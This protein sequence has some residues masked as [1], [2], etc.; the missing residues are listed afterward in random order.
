[1]KKNS[2]CLAIAIWLLFAMGSYAEVTLAGDGSPGSPYLISSADDLDAIRNYLHETDAYFKQTGP[3]DLKDWLIENKPDKGWIPIGGEYMKPFKG[4]FDGGGHS[5]T[6]LWIDNPDLRN[7][8]IFAVT[9]ENSS[10][11][12]MHIKIASPGIKG[13]AKVAGLVG[14][15]YGTISKCTVNIAEGVSIQG[16]EEDVA[17]L[18][19]S[20]YATGSITECSVNGRIEADNNDSWANLTVA[21]LVGWNRGSI[22][23]CFVDVEVDVNAVYAKVG[24]LVGDNGNYMDA[25]ITGCIVDVDIRV[26]GDNNEIGGLA[27]FNSGQISGSS[28]T[29]IITADQGG[30]VS[31]GG[32]VGHS[33][34]SINTSF[35][36]SVVT[37]M[38]DYNYVGGLIGSINEGNVT[39]CYAGGEVTSSGIKSSVGGLVGSFYSSELISCSYATG[40]VTSAGNSSKVGGLI[41]S[42]EG[43]VTNSFASS[44]VKSTGMKS[45]VGGFAGNF[46]SVVA[47][48]QISY[49]Y[50][51]GSVTAEGDESQVG[52]F[53]GYCKN[54][55]N[56][57][58]SI[59]LVKGTGNKVLA[60]GLVGAVSNSQEK[61]TSCFFLQD[62][63]TNKGLLGVAGTYSDYGGPNPYNVQVYNVFMSFSKSVVPRK[64]EDL[65]KKETF[66]VNNPDYLV[67][68][69]FLDN[70]D[71]YDD[72]NP[73]AVWLIDAG[74]TSPYLWWQEGI[75][76]IPVEDREQ[77]TYKVTL[78][79][80]DGYTIVKTND[81]SFESTEQDVKESTEFKFKI[82][83]DEDYDGSGVKVYIDPYGTQ[84][85]PV[86][87]I[88]SITV[89]SDITIRVEDIT[90]KSHTITFRPG[91]GYTFVKENG[92]DFIEAD[93]SVLHSTEFKFTI[94]ADAGY[95]QTNA[96]VYTTLSADPISPVDG[97][98]SIIVS[99][100]IDIWAEGITLNPAPNQTY[101]NMTLQ[102]ASGIQLQ[103]YTPGDHLFEEGDLMYLSFHPED[104][105]ATAENVLLLVDG[106]EKPV[107]KLGDMFYFSL[108]VDAN[109]T[110]EIAMRTYTVTLPETSGIIIDHGPGS[111]R[112]AYGNS[113]CFCL[114]PEQ[115]NS[116]D[117]VRVFAN[118]QELLHDG[119]RSDGSLYYTL[120]KVSSDVI[121]TIEGQSSTGNVDV[122]DTH[123]KITAGTGLLTIENE[124]GI[125]LELEIYTLGGQLYIS[126]SLPQGTST[127]MLPPGIY[128]VKAGNITTKVIIK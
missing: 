107:K 35:A 84:I 1:M 36:N 102:V 66:Q 88:Y 67:P 103:Y 122:E 24:G 112:V 25:Y 99:D 74:A 46:I 51:T 127:M 80:G 53:V 89:N 23:D 108:L 56:T 45:S 75:N 58:Y 42:V 96:K 16:M 37:T 123:V 121:V 70:K 31:V 94:K 120:N 6:G 40:S 124:E 17:G 27:G 78:S 117:G 109:H 118:G 12:N 114:T 22:T 82:K 68:W 113:F 100:D 52:G 104:P 39:N 49:S 54:T 116:C 13:N 47:G 125:V 97:V 48:D 71:Q 4:H 69:E 110:I 83:V 3:I 119:L 90:L 44:A 30:Y 128:I 20:N 101:H 34:S 33:Q 77:K 26:K 43:N 59:G 105:E 11:K 111:H 85:M 81:N 32:L 2:I 93:L 72:N 50:A 126:R 38:G 63:I 57:C 79:T 28:A 19:G 7:A 10:L 9:S 98:Y 29:G 8:G 61:I 87:G 55:I 73:A 18:V 106:V 64:A 14:S 5:I 115:G 65:K 41:G 91:T 86:N 21:G 92:D 76:P 95:N 60:G 15:N 62:W